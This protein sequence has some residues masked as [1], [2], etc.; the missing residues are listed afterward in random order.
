MW[1]LLKPGGRLLLTVPC[2][3]QACDEFIDR[4]EYGLL[5]PNE[6]GLFFFQRFYD[7]R[8]LS[9]NIFSVTGEPHRHSVYGE[10]KRGAYHSNQCSKMSDPEYPSWREPYMMATDYSYFDNVGHLPGV[11]VIA[12]EFVKT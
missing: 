2:A 1:R 8:L 9:D 3:A 11:G 4:N 6:D 12:M 7:E 10:K 5:A